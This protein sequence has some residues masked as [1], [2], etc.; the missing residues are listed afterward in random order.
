[1]LAVVVLGALAQGWLSRDR[2]I[3]ASPA[4]AAKPV[5]SATPAARTGPVVRAASYVGRPAAQVRTALTGLGL[6]PR[7]VYDGTGRPA[8]TV[9]AVTPTGSLAAGSQVTVHV[10]PAPAPRKGKGKGKKGDDD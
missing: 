7:L 3:A 5:A 8:G 10:V 2:P 9:S 4:P 6:R 1:M